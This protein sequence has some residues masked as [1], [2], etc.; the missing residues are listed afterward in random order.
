MSGTGRPR[1]NSQQKKTWARDK[2]RT[3][4]ALVHLGDGRVVRL[5]GP[6]MPD[7]EITE[8]PRFAWG[9]RTSLIANRRR[10]AN[11]SATCTS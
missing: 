10:G 5:A 9:C 7:L 8:N 1:I 11:G 4:R 3:Y 6:D 2:D